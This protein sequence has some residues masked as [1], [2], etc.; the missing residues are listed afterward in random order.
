MNQAS[1]VP[2]LI[3][4]RAGHHHRWPA[5][6]REMKKFRDVNVVAPELF[7][8][9]QLVTASLCLRRLAVGHYSSHDYEA[10]NHRL[11]VGGDSK[12]GETIV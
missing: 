12:Q 11:K 2:S 5:L 1:E 6:L 8:Q 7:P 4:K 3:G 9:N 10:K